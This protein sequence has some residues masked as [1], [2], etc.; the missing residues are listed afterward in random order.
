MVTVL[1]Y[2]YFW[3][4]KT[5]SLHDNPQWVIRFTTWFYIQ[6]DKMLCQELKEVSNDLNSIVHGLYWTVS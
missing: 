6:M 4:K 3:S 1:F 5:F 2:I